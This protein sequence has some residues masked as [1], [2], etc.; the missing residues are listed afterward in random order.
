MKKF[1][2]ILDNV[3]VEILPPEEKIGGIFIPTANQNILPRQYA[4]VIA[5]GPGKR[6]KNGGHKSMSVDVGDIVIIGD[7]YN[8][9]PIS[10]G[11]NK[12]IFVYKEDSLACVVDDYK[13]ES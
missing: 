9:V 3:I 10:N 11:E 2:P 7:E 13:K 8:C 5:V 1:N 6:S 4:K 12:R